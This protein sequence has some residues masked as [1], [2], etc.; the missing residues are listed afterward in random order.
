MIKSFDIIHKQTDIAFY[1]GVLTSAFLFARSLGTLLWGSFSDY[2]GGRKLVLLTGTLGSMICFL[3]FGLSQ[4]YS[5]V[6]NISYSTFQGL[7]LGSVLSSVLRVH[8][9]Q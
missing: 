1:V 8:K 6:H 7:I 9:C 5:W 2:I 4:T 3:G